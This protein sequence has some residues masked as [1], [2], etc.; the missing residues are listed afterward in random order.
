MIS[1][2]IDLNLPE[3]EYLADHLHPEECRR[4]TAALHFNS[5]QQPNALDQ[6]GKKYCFCDLS[7]HVER[8]YRKESIE[9]NSMY[10]I[11]F[12]LEFC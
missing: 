4:L 9:G 2:T 12:A 11:A 6:A 10:Q 7:M 3:L 8:F 1:C 5:Y